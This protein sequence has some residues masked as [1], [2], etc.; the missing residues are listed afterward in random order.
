MQKSKSPSAVPVAPRAKGNA[1]K[2]KKKS[3]PLPYPYLQLAMNPVSAPLSAAGRPDF[4]CQR[5]CVHREEGVLQ[6]S[7]DANG[8][9]FVAVLPRLHQIVTRPSTVTST[10]VAG[11]FDSQTECT[12]YTAFTSSFSTYRV[13]HLIAEI[14]YEGRQDETQGVLMGYSGLAWNGTLANWVNEQDYVECTAAEGEVAL[15][16]SFH[17]NDFVAVTDLTGPSPSQV[18]C[19]AGTG[20]PVSKTNLIRL[21][22]TVDFEATCP[23]TSLMSRS[24]TV[25]AVSPAQTAAAASANGGKASA[26]AGKGAL[27]KLLAYTEKAVLLGAEINGIIK[28][29]RPVAQAVAELALI[30]G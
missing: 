19:F 15:K 30:L 1:S 12:N 11:Q 16:A 8:N 27:D 2:R 17:D 9:F 23:M 14:T 18:L 3:L 7:S 20:L 22:Y 6:I 26:V 21:K 29:A 10:D 25:T 4:N 24:T 13:L 5:T 28:K